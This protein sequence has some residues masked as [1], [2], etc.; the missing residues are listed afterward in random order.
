MPIVMVVLMLGAPKGRAAA[1]TFLAGWMVGLAVVGAVLLLVASGE[2]ASEV[3][4]PVDWVSVVKIG[5]GIALLVL[6][7]TQW[8]RRPRGDAA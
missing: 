8:R 2:R 3:G 1:L 4:G 6:A 5:L 7:V